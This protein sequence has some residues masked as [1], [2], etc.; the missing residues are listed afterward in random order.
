M[1]VA[2]HSM[3]HVWQSQG[4]EDRLETKIWDVPHQFNAAMQDEAFDWLDRQMTGITPS[5]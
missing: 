3:R 5:P 1:K 4:A 2:H